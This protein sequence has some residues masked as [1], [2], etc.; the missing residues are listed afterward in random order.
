MEGEPLLGEN[1]GCERDPHPEA[2]LSP[3]EARAHLIR[4]S[5]GQHFFPI[6]KSL[7]QSKLYMELHHIKRTE[8]KLTCRAGGSKVS[9]F[10]R[11]LT[12]APSTPPTNPVENHWCKPVVLEVKPQSGSSSQELVRK[13][14]IFR[15]HPRPTD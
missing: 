15:P 9:S 3:L 8:A 11:T 14:H 7:L 6:T 4:V 1:I 5:E 13:M 2:S 10:T 12:K